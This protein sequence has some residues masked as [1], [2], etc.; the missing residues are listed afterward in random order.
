MLSCPN[1]LLVLLTNYCNALYYYTLATINRTCKKKKFNVMPH[2]FCKCKLKV[3]LVY[4]VFIHL[5]VS[6]STQLVFNTAQ[7]T[8]STH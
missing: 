7:F 8:P 4:V 5:L 3:A 2:L 6:L 1:K